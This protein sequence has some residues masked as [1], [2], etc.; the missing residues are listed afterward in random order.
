MRASRLIQVSPPF[1]GDGASDIVLLKV[2]RALKSLRALRIVRSSASFMCSFLHLLLR[3]APYFFSHLPFNVAGQPEV[4]VL[5]F[6]EHLMRPRRASP[7][8]C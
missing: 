7:E 6:S 1:S 5:V 8:T 2:M 3:V 4:N